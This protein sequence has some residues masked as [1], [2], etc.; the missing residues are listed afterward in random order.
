MNKFVKISMALA[1]GGGVI[2][3][4]HALTNE[5]DYYTVNVEDLDSEL[6]QLDPDMLT[7]MPI[8]VSS[9][10]LNDD[11]KA[12]VNDGPKLASKPAVESNATESDSKDVSVEEIMKGYENLKEGSVGSAAP[13]SE[14]PSNIS[15]IVKS[16]CGVGVLGAIFFVIKKFLM[17]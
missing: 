10:E 14:E 3:S 7:V 8:P 4:A 12:L 6:G 16:V 5:D 11:I 15:M 13:V 17:K 9:D 1:I 2:M